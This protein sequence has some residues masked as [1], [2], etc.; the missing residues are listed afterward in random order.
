MVMD[1]I[2]GPT[3]QTLVFPGQPLSEA[4]GINYIRQVGAALKVVHQKGLLHRDIK[5]ANILLRQGSQ[6]VVLIDF[7]IAREF[8]PDA[9]KTHTRIVSDGYAPLEQYLSNEKPTPA[10]DVYGLAATLYALLTG[11]VPIPAVIRDRQPMPA[12]RD[13]QP[14]L[15]FAVNQAIMRG[16]AVEA[17]YRPGSV[18]EWLSLLPE[19]EFEPTK[20]T[21]PQSN[22]TYSGATVPLLPQQPPQVAAESS[23]LPQILG[24][25][26]WLIGGTLAIAT[27]LVALL[28]VWSHSPQTT[29]PPTSQPA[30]PPTQQ[31]PSP[32]VLP[33][34]N[35]QNA[36]K[37]PAAPLEDSNS[38]P[39]EKA[40]V[41]H[42]SPS[43][44]SP[45][46]ESSPTPAPV[47]STSTPVNINP[48]PRGKTPSPASQQI[49]ASG[50]SESQPPTPTQKPP[51]NPETPP[52]PESTS[53]P[54]EKTPTQPPPE[55]IQPKKPEPAQAQEPKN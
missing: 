22:H 13:L 50:S 20:S 38:S 25:N 16:M 19:T 53:Q 40:P 28:T 54:V 55:A 4:T 23:P 1:Y 7:G 49:P 44:S 2:A 21:V 39:P 29:P 42:S 10:S 27:T 14:Q 37:D 48:L 18:D 46:V 26:S 5:P 17:R 12:P 6:E 35:A 47:S 15:S 8:T 36:P 24:A 51:I 31:S 32:I 30:T 3:L 33:T 34:N 52:P 11:Q 9:S 45:P 41:R 43:K